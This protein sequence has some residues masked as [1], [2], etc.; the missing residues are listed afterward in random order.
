MS[1]VPARI[2]FLHPDTYGDLVLFEPVLR[3]V[4]EH[5]PQTEIGVLIRAPYLDAAPLLAEEGAIRWLTTTCN[6]YRQS[7]RENR[8]ALED[9]HGAVLDFNPDWLVAACLERTWLDAAVASFL[10]G[11]RQ[12]SMGDGD[13]PAV[14][15]AALEAE[16]GIDWAAVHW[17]KIP[18]E[19]AQLE[20]EKNLL[21]AGALLGREAPRWWPV[22]RV[23]PAD[24][25]RADEILAQAGLSRGA[26]AAGCAAGTANVRIKAWPPERFAESITW[27]ERERG[28]TTLLIGHESEREA[29]E[30]VRDA[31]T[32]AG[33][34]PALWLGREGEIGLLAALL[35][36][37]RF[38]LGNDT[39]AVHLAA[40]LGRPVASIFG[41]G[42]WPRFKPVARRS[43]VVVQPLACF[44]CGWDCLFGY[45]PC[46]REIHAAAV[47]SALE[48]LLAAED[49][50]A[51]REF[52]VADAIPA[53]GHALIAGAAARG[54]IEGRGPVSAP[55]LTEL[56]KRLD[57]SETD[58]AARL[59]VIEAQ[60][61]EAGCLRERLGRIEGE[62]SLL[63]A[64]LED[65]R[66]H[67]ERSESDREKRLGVIEEQGREISRLQAEAS[68]WMQ[69]AGELWP[70]LNA[71]TN[72]RNL[73]ASQWEDLRGRFEQ[74][75]ADRE[76]RL[77]VIKTQGAEMSRLHA[78]AA[79]WIQEAADL[80]PRLNAAEN[81]RNLLTAQHE[82]LREHLERSEADR[83]ARLTVIEQRGT[84][85]ERLQSELA[86]ALAE[87]DAAEGKRKAAIDEGRALERT[88]ADLSRTIADLH[89]TV[90]DLQGANAKLHDTN[91]ALHNANG[92]L[93][94]ALAGLHNRIGELERRKRKIDRLWSTWVLKRL[95]LWPR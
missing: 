49:D 28:V 90:A 35:E 32:G 91:A 37:S 16:S 7:P 20:W 71:A 44:G 67:F 53:A 18:V 29:L 21:L 27:L 59:A 1:H 45:A 26:F 87:W 23:Q 55:E 17:E 57:F 78:E 6:P 70:R 5:W 4:R 66:G 94:R 46:V 2:L 68:R 84:E 13:L 65:L 83:A 10:P 63:I 52:T 69:E 43:A 73:L 41:G 76:A 42:H 58:R 39:G 89:H 60:G 33:A 3:L 95:H 24:R 74:S 75:E 40:G 86:R 50:N 64:Q 62:R 14:A 34:H 54:G 82:D 48:W 77:T 15:H 79:R 93:Q 81:V 85:C 56:F 80:W 72:E 31:A 9:L 38:Y 12:F 22:V 47:Q 25:Q 92:D 36:A 30:S 19:N 88:I 11:A 51:E 61:D 8:A